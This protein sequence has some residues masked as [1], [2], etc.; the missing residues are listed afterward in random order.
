MRTTSSSQQVRVDGYSTLRLTL[1]PTP[2][3]R[4]G[5]FHTR[6]FVTVPAGGRTTPCVRNLWCMHVHPWKNKRVPWTQMGTVLW[7]ISYSRFGLAVVVRGR[8]CQRQPVPHRN[9]LTLRETGR[10]ALS[11]TDTTPA[12]QRSSVPRT[13][14]R[15]VSAHSLISCCSSVL[16][17]VCVRACPCACKGFITGPFMLSIT[18]PVDNNQCMYILNVYLTFKASSWARK[19]CSVLLNI[20]HDIDK[21]YNSEIQ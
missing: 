20:K 17:C 7:T 15:A 19:R 5:Y 18:S 12:L 9:P 4:E 21:A 1:F 6:T 3:R 11:I 13:S 8:K 14:A 10:L 16:V 2:L